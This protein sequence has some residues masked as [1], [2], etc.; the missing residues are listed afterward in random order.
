MKRLSSI[1][2]ASVICGLFGAPT[3]ARAKEK[4]RKTSKHH[5]LKKEVLWPMRTIGEL[6]ED[7]ALPALVAIRAACLAEGDGPPGSG[8]CTV[9]LRLCGYTPG[10]RA[11]IEARVG[12]RRFAVKAY[13]TDPAR[14]A[15]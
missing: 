8:D 11:T 5:G 13:A 10:S 7:P 3:E 12:P 4:E 6:P 2:V 14:E 1:T 15:A 9:E